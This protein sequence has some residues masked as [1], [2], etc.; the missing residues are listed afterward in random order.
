[1]KM[2]RL[3]VF[4]GIILAIVP[5]ATVTYRLVNVTPPD[6]TSGDAQVIAIFN[7]ASCSLC[8]RQNSK[9]PFYT[10][11]PIVGNIM[12]NGENRGFLR[13]DIGE[14]IDR[15]NRGEAVNETVL[16]KMEMATVTRPNMP[17][18]GYFLTRWGSS[19]TSA[20]REILREWIA[21]HR[22]KF[23][24]N[25]LAADRFRNEPV[26]PLPASIPVDERIAALGKKLFH[27]TRLSHGSTISCSSCHNLNTGGADGR[28]YP[29]GIDR[30]LGRVNTPTVFNACLNGS[31]FR[32]GRAPDLKTQT[33]EHLADPLAMNAV[34]FD[35][36]MEKLLNDG[37]LKQSFDRLYEDGMTAS[38]IADAIE[39]FE[40][41]LLTPDCRFDRYLRGETG[42]LDESGIRGYEI[43]KS[44]R[45]ATCHAGVI[46]G[47]LS[48]ER[49]GIH[50]DYFKDRGWEITK[51]DLGRFNQTSRKN[52]RYRFKVP[53][54]RNVALTK[55]YFHDGSRQTL[56]DAIK[57]MGTYQSG[58]SLKDSEIRAITSFL[59][60]LTGEY[61]K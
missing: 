42:I 23:Y 27:D 54:L 39:S 28:Q 53:G 25:P 15:I 40:K 58:R 55:P 45:C 34:P 8:H 6:G 21:G 44:N 57:T 47:G 31:Q 41:T 29:E 30:I 56:Y 48:H 26:R 11:F 33:A 59:E 46:L 22:E 2:K 35:R 60:S 61:E 51:E 38:S 4:A 19:I 50:G 43:F 32:D 20:K 24:P 36:I 7:D 12:R 3:M 18:A 13:F 17:P 16:A 1:M 9:L 14:S 10:G 49:M 52:D 5:V 37:D